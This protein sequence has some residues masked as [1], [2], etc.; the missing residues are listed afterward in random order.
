MAHIE[1]LPRR[2]SGRDAVRASLAR[3][4]RRR[5]R[6]GERRGG[7]PR[8]RA[9]WCPTSPVTAT[10]PAPRHGAYDPLSPVTLARWTLGGRGLLVGVGQNAHGAL[11]P[12][13]R[14]RLRRGRPSST[15][16]GV[17]GRTRTTP[18]PTCTPTCER[19]SPTTASIAPA[20]P[21]GLDPRTTHGYGVHV[22]AAFAQRF[23]GA[24]TCPVLAVETPASPT[25]P[26]ERER[27]RGLVRRPD[28]ARRAARVHGGRR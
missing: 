4:R 8:R 3:P 10:T 7:P 19:S 27:A 12:G 23:W 6:A 2:R 17:R 26:S 24:I 14:R 28:D 9:G 15:A 21:A 1:A 13:G 22:S 5:R 25:P 11:D 20:P 16:C 18:S